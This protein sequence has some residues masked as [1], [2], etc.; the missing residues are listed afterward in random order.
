VKQRQGTVIDEQRQR[1]PL[2][3][4][5]VHS[6]DV[7]GL[8]NGLVNLINRIP[9][10]LYRHAI[11][12]MTDYTDFYRRI[13]QPGVNVYA[14]HKK[15]GKDLKVYFKLWRLLRE[16]R[17][18]IVH[19]RNLATLEGAVVARLA[20]V[21]HRVHGEH[22]R[23][24]HDIDG[25]NPKYLLLRRLCQPFVQRYITL[26]QDLDNWLR[27]IVRV[28][29]YKVTQLYNGVD[30][31]RFNSQGERAELPLWKGERENYL[32]IGTVGR[33][34]IVKDQVNLVKAFLQLL[35][36]QPELKQNVRLLI[37]G[38]GALMPEI[39]SFIE[40]HHLQGLVWLPGT[41]DDIPALMRSMDI[42]VLPSK[43]EGISNTILEAMSCGLP[44]IATRVGGNPEL[45]VDNETGC[46][47]PM[48]NPEALARAM[49]RYIHDKNLIDQHGAKGRI[50]VEQAFSIHAMVDKYLDV[51]NELLAHHHKQTRGQSI[52]R[53]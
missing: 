29:D 48:Q 11:I 41:R 21:K 1:V 50:R 33:L 39:V 31:Q 3:V 24:I 19:T 45:I 23:D 43:A 13:S 17:P 44:V 30:N 35:Q 36:W 18:E 49:Q 4:H 2:I 15:P 47:V 22:G 46:L 8:E 9:P 7:G 37:V 14:L 51:Y 5:I 12:C 20:G 16:L 34:Q 28:P 6:L 25:R 26:S 38:D 53:V 40:Q 27:N 10:E 52:K 32:V 42:F